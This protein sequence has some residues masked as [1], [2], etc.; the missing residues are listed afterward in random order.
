MCAHRLAVPA[1]ALVVGASLVVV[2]V[3]LLPRLLRRQV[4]P[5][6]PVPLLISW[7]PGVG[8]PAPWHSSDA[9]H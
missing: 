2:A 3:V 7:G 6:L 9:L 1:M 4:F 8:D 5:P